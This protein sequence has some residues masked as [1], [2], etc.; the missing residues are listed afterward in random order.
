MSKKINLKVEGVISL[1]QADFDRFCAKV[2]DTLDTL[3][4]LAKEYRTTEDLYAVESLKRE[5]NS[6]LQYLGTLY[7]Y[8]K[9]HKGPNHTYL[10]I[11]I[12]QLKARTLEAMCPEGKGMTTAKDTYYIQPVYVQQI[13]NIE[14]IKRFFTE[15]EIMYEHYCTTLQCIQQS[16]AVARGEFNSSKAD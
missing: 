8:T 1:G 10:E 16:V 2:A 11:A 14:N 12:K 4:G 6:H 9:V 5:F 3:K 7:S 13:E 15:I